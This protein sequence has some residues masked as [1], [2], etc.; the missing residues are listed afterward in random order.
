MENFT[1][2]KRKKKEKNVVCVN[3][4]LKIDPTKVGCLAKMSFQTFYCLWNKIH[5]LSAL[6]KII[7]TVSKVKYRLL[8]NCIKRLII[9]DYTFAI[10]TF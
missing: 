10:C 9:D 7:K 5:I 8:F 4:C 3:F 1:M 2:Q 6:F